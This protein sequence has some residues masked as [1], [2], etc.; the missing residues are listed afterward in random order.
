MF[1]A[2][3][4]L[5]LL[6]LDSGAA[7][8]FG[9]L[10]TSPQGHGLSDAKYS[11]CNCHSVNDLQSFSPSTAMLLIAVPTPGRKL[12]TIPDRFCGE[13]WRNAHYYRELVGHILGKSENSSAAALKRLVL[14][15]YFPV[16]HTFQ[17]SSNVQPNGFTSA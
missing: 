13:Q 10:P 1:W 4:V 3:S 7:F 5:S 11:L 9:I 8:A 14:V 16:T 17:Y 15:T 6:G 12:T 2:A